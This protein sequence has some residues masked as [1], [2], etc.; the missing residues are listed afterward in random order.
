[1]RGRLIGVRFPK[2]KVHGETRIVEQRRSPRP[3]RDPRVTRP[4]SGTTSPP[5]DVPDEYADVQREYPIFFRKDPTN[6][7]FASVAL[8]G[9]QEGEKLVLEAGAGTRSICRGWS[10]AARF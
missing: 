9:L 8:L 5:S 3:A 6:G 1:M 2:R 10:G 4:E 7:E